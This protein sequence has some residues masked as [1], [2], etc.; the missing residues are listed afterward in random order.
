MDFKFQN[1]F[2]N[3]LL[4]NLFLY[5]FSLMLTAKTR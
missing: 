4:K 2:I 3:I 1:L 5:R